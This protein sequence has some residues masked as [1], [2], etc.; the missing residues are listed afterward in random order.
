MVR[1][2]IFKEYQPCPH[3]RFKS[4]KLAWAG[5]RRLAVASAVVEKLGH[6][7]QQYIV[8]IVRSPHRRHYRL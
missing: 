7:T 1:Q 8:R 4:V 2:L 3:V 6:V 5:S